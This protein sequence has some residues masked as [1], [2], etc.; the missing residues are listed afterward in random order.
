M[1]VKVKFKLTQ[2]VL[3]MKTYGEG[4]GNGIEAYK[5]E[6][7]YTYEIDNRPLKNLVENDI[8]INS[9]IQ[10]MTP[11]YPIS[12]EEP[13]G[14]RRQFSFPQNEKANPGSIEVWM[15]GN[16]YSPMNI[17]LINDNT[18]FEISINDIVP[19]ADDDFYFVYRVL[20]ELNVIEELIDFEV[21]GNYIGQVA[22]RKILRA[23]VRISFF[24]TDLV[25][26]DSNGDLILISDDSFVGTIDYDTG[27]YDFTYE[28]LTSGVPD[29]SG[30]V[31]LFKY[32]NYKE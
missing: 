2:E 23:S 16:K 24:G 21:S 32:Q 20:N 13:D 4:E 11:K 1:K 3:I 25:K 9:Q 19:E 14:M 5:R 28:F 30:E 10:S 15:N 27:E 12:G 7:P 6:D 31:I 17:T 18:G 26:D 8:I 22:G 29:E